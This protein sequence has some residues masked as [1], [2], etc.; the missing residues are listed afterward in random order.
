M[1]NA[2][3]LLVIGAGMA[4]L[5]AA[6]RAASRGAT[7]TVVEKGREIGG[8]ARFA[9]YAWTAPTRQIMAEINPHGDEELRNAVVDDFASGLDWI[10]GRG[11]ECADGVPVLRYGIGHAFDTNQYLD[12]CAREIKDAGNTIHTGALVQGLLTEAGAVV[13]AT[14]RF[15]DGEERELRARRVLLATGGFQANAELVEKHLHPLASRF[16]LRSN[17]NSDG[18]GLA[19]AESVDAAVGFEDAGFYGHLIPSGLEFRDSGDFVG[20]SLY[21]SEHALLFNLEGERFIDETQGDHLT[22]MALMEQPEARGLL[23]ADE[24]V[25]RDWICGSYVEGAV[26]VDKYTEA[27]KR[28]GRCGL[29]ETLE[30]FEYLPEEWGYDGATIAEA[31]RR[32]NEAGQKVVPPREYDFSPL[33]RG[34]YYIIETT[35]AV[36]FPFVGIRIGADTS[37]LRADGTA[38]PGLLAAGSDTGGV[39]RRAYAGGLAPALVFGLRAGDAAT[40]D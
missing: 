14:V 18:G 35:P 3:D 24:R 15:D 9:G 29:A 16:P 11:V 1:E 8:S 22:A 34:P 13:G 32:V 12:A 23:V 6:A 30:D 39:Y 26:A 36:T 37:V 2:V 33:D 19:L 7:V 4:G 40:S 25:Y 31:I 5:T 27:A 21:Y 38:I 17:P 20:I 28:G 10:R